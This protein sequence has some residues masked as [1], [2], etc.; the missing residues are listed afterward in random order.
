MVA[1]IGDD[2]KE[3][4]G[5]GAMNLVFLAQKK[6]EQYKKL[7]EKA[8]HICVRVCV[9]IYICVF[10]SCFNQNKSFVSTFVGVCVFGVVF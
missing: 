6:E 9:C 4:E 3:E 8:L 2:Y 7:K 10:F 5:G 1:P